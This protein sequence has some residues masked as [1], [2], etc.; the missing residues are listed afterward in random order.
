MANDDEPVSGICADDWQE[1]FDDVVAALLPGVPEA[2]M[3]EAD[4]RAETGRCHC[5][6]SISD[7]IADL[8]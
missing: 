8:M 4:Q 7:E 5:E 3:G 1:S 6:L 2:G